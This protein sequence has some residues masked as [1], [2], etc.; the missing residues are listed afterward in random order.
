LNWGLLKRFAT[1]GNL[2]WLGGFMLVFWSPFWGSFRLP[3]LVLATM[4]L[5]LQLR[6]RRLLPTDTAGLRLTWVFALL[7]LPALLSSINAIDGRTAAIVCLALLLHYWA[8]LALLRGLGD[9][10]HT[11]MLT[12]LGYMLLFW[13]IDGSVQW[14]WGEDLF[15]MP[16]TEDKRVVGPFDGNLRMGLFMAVLAPLLLWPLADKRPGL[17]ILALLPILAISTLAGTRAN[18]VFLL[19]AVIWLMARLKN[20]RLRS[21]LVA[22]CLL[23]VLIIPSSPALKERVAHNYGEPLQTKTLSN[24]DSLFHS[25]DKISSY[26]L[27]IWETAGRMVADRPWL[28]IGPG[29]FDLA[30]ARYATRQ[31]DPF[32]LANVHGKHAYHAH[33][34]YVSAAAE[35]GLLGLA[36]LLA[37][38]ALTARWYW[39][40]LPQARDAARPWMVCLAIIAFPVNSQPI[41]FSGWWFPV[42]LLLYCGLLAALAQ[43]GTSTSRPAVRESADCYPIGTSHA[44]SFQTPQPYAQAAVQQDLRHASAEGVSLQTTQ[45]R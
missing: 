7:L 12:W 16:L 20:W 31:D 30:Y 9:Q 22:A 41:L 36:G 10:R 28:G 6:G 43:D 1:F 29:N 25:L 37:V 32:R 21:A 2:A 13:C 8:G 5:G 34:M 3:L 26:R 27:S 14:L 18:L 42:V 23:P 39:R 24:P 4:G 45:P 35:T 15:G 19:L 38:I 11:L 33:Q 17:A 44:A 40:A